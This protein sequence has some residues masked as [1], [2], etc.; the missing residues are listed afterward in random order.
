MRSPPMRREGVIKGISS[1]GQIWGWPTEVDTYLL[2]YNKR[3][4]AEAGLQRAADN[5]DELKTMSAAISKKDDTGAVTQVGYG[6]ITGWDSG[7]VHPWATLLMS[8][9][10]QY[11]TDDMTATA[12]DSP[13]GLETLQ[14]YADLVANGGADVSMAAHG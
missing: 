6:I 1:D 10:G 14:L 2:I 7:V 12:F 11:L 8:N 13:Q 5:W 3:T 9:G 4:A